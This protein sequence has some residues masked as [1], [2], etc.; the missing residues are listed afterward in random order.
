MPLDIVDANKGRTGLVKYFP[1]GVVVGITPFNFPLNL[2]AHKVAPA[3]AAG[4]PIIIKPAT[5]TPLA[6]LE[7]AN[8]IKESGLDDK[9]FSVVTCKGSDME[10][11]MRSAKVKK[12][13]FT[14]SPE[15]GYMIKEKAYD[16]KVTLELGGNA[17]AIVSNLDDIDDVV[18]RSVSGGFAYQGQVC[19]HLQRIYIQEDHYDNFKTKFIDETKRLVLGSQQDINVDIGPMIDSGEADRVI[20][21]IEEA[22]RNGASILVGGERE[23]NIVTPTIIENCDHE[24]K[25]NSLEVFG[26]V[27]VLH[28]YKKFKDAVDLVNDSKYGLQAGVFTNDMREIMYA[29]DNLEVGGVVVNDVPTFRSDNQPYGGVKQSGSGREGVKYA[30]EE[31][32]ELKI[33]SLTN[34]QL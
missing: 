30:I 25:V 18:K 24:E 32:S 2:V 5:Q 15:V 21:W 17:A 7:L 16:K 11:A 27:V 4:C 29:F 19:I 23:G 33:L 6:S 26:P 20:S 1:I 3:I 9:L 14:G 34:Y 13:S 22:K 10:L 28:K 8:I 31:M 12:I